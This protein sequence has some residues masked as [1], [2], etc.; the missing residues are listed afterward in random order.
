MQLC[1]IFVVSE[2]CVEI[3]VECMIPINGQEMW[4]VRKSVQFK[5]ICI[6]LQEDILTSWMLGVLNFQCIDLIMLF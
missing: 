6:N 5:R 1:I 3:P 4:I 2:K